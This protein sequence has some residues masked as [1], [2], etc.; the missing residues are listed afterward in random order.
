[1]IAEEGVLPGEVSPAV[2]TDDKAT[3]DAASS[4]PLVSDADSDALV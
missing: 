3:S 1:M 4:V 2:I